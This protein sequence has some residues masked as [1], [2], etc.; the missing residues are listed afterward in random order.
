MAHATHLVVRDAALAR[1]VTLVGGMICFRFAVLSIL[2]I[3]EALGFLGKRALDHLRI[4]TVAG[5]GN[6]SGVGI[7]MLAESQ[8]PRWSH[9]RLVPGHCTDAL[10]YQRARE[11]TSPSTGG[12]DWRHDVWTSNCPTPTVRDVREKV[13]V[14][15][16]FCRSRDL[17]QTSDGAQVA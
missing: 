8:D 9:A 13:H 1:F 5:S 2:G 12:V 15:V 10:G 6:F 11:F 7:R 3:I 14:P 4:T 17:T 16:Q